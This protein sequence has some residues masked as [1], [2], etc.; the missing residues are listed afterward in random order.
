MRENRVRLCFYVSMACRN[1]CPRTV[2]AAAAATGNVVTDKN[3]TNILDEQ[4][5][6][7]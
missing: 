1:F 7:N 6:I 5:I 4:E 3:F 2:P